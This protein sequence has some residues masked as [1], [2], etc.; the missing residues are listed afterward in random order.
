MNTIADTSSKVWILIFRDQVKLLKKSTIPK[1]AIVRSSGAQIESICFLKWALQGLISAFL[2]EMQLNLFCSV[3]NK[4][5]LLLPLLHV[6][7]RTTDG[8][9]D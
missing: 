5:Q 8:C 3:H 7:L 4:L 9:L 6:P 2:V 1:F